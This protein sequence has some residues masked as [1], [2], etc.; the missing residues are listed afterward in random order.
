MANPAITGD[1]MMAILAICSI[2]CT[3]AMLLVD[4]RE[5]L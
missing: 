5:F 3:I 1:E 4:V 2:V